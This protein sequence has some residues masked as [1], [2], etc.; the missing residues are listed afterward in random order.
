MYAVVMFVRGLLKSTVQRREKLEALVI[1]END[2]HFL[3]DY[4]GTQSDV[5]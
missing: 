3:T 2:K 5:N 1:H 4:I